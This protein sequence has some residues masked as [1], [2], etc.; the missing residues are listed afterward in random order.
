[1]S[2]NAFALNFAFCVLG[3]AYQSTA[4]CQDTPADLSSPLGVLAKVLDERRSIKTC[5]VSGL[6]TWEDGTTLQFETWIH[7]DRYRADRTYLAN[8]H[9]PG[10]NGDTRRSVRQ[11][12]RLRTV[13]SRYT[14][15]LSLI[16]QTEEAYLMNSKLFGISSGPTPRQR[17]RK[18]ID[19]TIVAKIVSRGKE[20]M[21]D[22][23][24]EHDTECT[25][26][27]VDRGDGYRYE[28]WIDSNSVYRGC[29]IL[30]EA[31]EGQTVWIVSDTVRN[32]IRFPTEMQSSWHNPTVDIEESVVLDLVELNEPID[33]SVFTF[34]GM[35][36]EDGESVTVRDGSLDGTD[37]AKGIF[38]DGQ[39]VPD[40]TLVPLRP[41][42]EIV[43]L[44]DA[45]PA[46]RSRRWFLGFSLVLFGVFVVG[47]LVF[48]AH[49]RRSNR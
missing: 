11:G 24:I 2:S 13:H 37:F 41:D 10:Q 33:D 28:A 38:V 3:F 9:D 45:E 18:T 21:I 39:I 17:M 7:G 25:A 48:N 43:T 20:A 49:R 12:D 6:A 42:A 1:M 5:H 36:V 34:A 31:G 47:R 40:P 23:A 27:I 30:N 16:T 32:G 15:E 46:P 26:I 44:A 29:A 14:S 4:V 35:G 8:A 22:T 19:D